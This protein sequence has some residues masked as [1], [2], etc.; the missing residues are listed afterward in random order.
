MIY[1]W[2]S[3]CDH[4]GSKNCK[5]LCTCLA[6][7]CDHMQIT[8]FMDRCKCGSRLKEDRAHSGGPRFASAE[9]SLCA[10]NCKSFFYGIKNCVHVHA[11]V[12][13]IIQQSRNMAAGEQRSRD[14]FRGAVQVS[15]GD[16]GRWEAGDCLD[17][18]KLY[19]VVLR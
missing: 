9:R 17:G 11:R 15:L 1:D 13:F 3:V 8:I 6:F 4:L 14:S 12:S 19:F 7:I 2:G 5:L 16:N 18:S 10:F